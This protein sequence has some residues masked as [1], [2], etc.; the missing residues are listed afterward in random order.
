MNKASF[1]NDK[2]IINWDGTLPPGTPS[3]AIH[4]DEDVIHFW[5][6]L[7]GFAKWSNRMAAYT[8]NLSLQN[9]ER[10][11]RQFPNIQ[12]KNE[13][14]IFKLRTQKTFFQKMIEMAYKVKTLPYERL[15]KYD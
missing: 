3:A 8:T 2:I 13:S 4:N 5:S 10:I 6:H 9:I 11:N 1:W 14:Q 7:T 12:W 15:P